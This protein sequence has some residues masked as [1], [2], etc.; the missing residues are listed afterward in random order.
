MKKTTVRN[1]DISDTITQIDL[2]DSIPQINSDGLQSLFPHRGD[3][4]LPSPGASHLQFRSIDGS[5]NNLTH[6][7]FNQAGSDF[8][9]VGPANFADGVDAMV[10]APNARM[11]SNV[12][13]AGNGDIPN[14]E[15]LSGMMY[16]WGQFIDHD[17]DLANQDRPR[18]S[19]L[20]ALPGIRI[21]SPARQFR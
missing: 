10:A 3:G 21:S 6:A 18:I 12:V 20:R 19:P 16:A 7:S 2:S 1:S 14:P 15:G 9:R 8:T 13:V 17:L 5:D 4:H 11:I